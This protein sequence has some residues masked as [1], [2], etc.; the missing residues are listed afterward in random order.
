MIR[1]VFDT[2]SFLLECFFCCGN[3]VAV[4]DKDSGEGGVDEAG[5]TIGF[6]RGGVSLH[7]MRTVK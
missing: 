6:E 1:D 3:D 4:Y 7:R 5:G 2:N